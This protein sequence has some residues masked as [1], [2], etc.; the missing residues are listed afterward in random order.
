MISIP[1]Y[2]QTT[3]YHL[4]NNSKNYSSLCMDFN[5]FLL[6]PLS[7]MWTFSF[8]LEDY[9]DHRV[10]KS[11]GNQHFIPIFI[12]VLSAW[13]T[14][15]IFYWDPKGFEEWVSLDTRFTVSVNT[16]LL[17]CSE[18]L[19]ALVPLSIKTPQGQYQSIWERSI[20]WLNS[21]MPVKFFY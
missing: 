20:M 4:Q 17:R 6:I 1:N 19:C 7:W 3:E 9:T 16:A 11:T 8:M 5:I 2:Q 10:S 14:P 13:H 18:V 21:L 15:K 12:G